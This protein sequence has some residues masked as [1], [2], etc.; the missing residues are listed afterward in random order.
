MSQCFYC[1]IQKLV[2][3]FLSTGNLGYRSP[4]WY[5]VHET[6]FW[7]L[8]YVTGID[9]GA[10]EMLWGSI[11][12]ENLELGWAW[13]YTTHTLGC[14]C[15]EVWQCWQWVSAVDGSYQVSAPI[16]WAPCRQSS[17]EDLAPTQLLSFRQCF[18]PWKLLGLSFT[19]V[20]SLS[21]GLP[22]F[23]LSSMFFLSSQT[24]LASYTNSL[25]TPLYKNSLLS[26][27]LFLDNKVDPVY[28]FK[29]EPPLLVTTKLL[30]PLH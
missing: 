2:Q 8:N 15:L 11:P 12:W 13:Q 22:A 21:L 20:F 30:P 7:A 18:I 10:E 28:L 26:L 17:H 23:R 4:C 27:C 24:V 25:F 19:H 6:S 9:C 1:I 3:E 16:R 14:K 5:T 29:R